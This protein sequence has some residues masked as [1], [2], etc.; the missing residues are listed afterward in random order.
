MLMAARLA[1]VSS[2]IAAVAAIAIL[3]I[4]VWIGVETRRMAAAATADAKAARDAVGSAAEQ[5][6]IARESLWAQQKPVLIEAVRLVSINQHD[7]EMVKFQDGTWT[8]P[9]L[10]EAHVLC[11]SGKAAYVSLPERNVGRGVA[12]V[13]SATLLVEGTGSEPLRVGGAYLRR[14]HVPPRETVRM[15]FVIAPGTTS[16]EAV[17]DAINEAGSLSVSIGYSDLA[18]N[19]QESRYD[20]RRELGWDVAF[21]RVSPSSRV[22]T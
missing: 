22:A 15:D 3:I 9:M 16:Y 6:A 14:R 10:G 19:A 7:R 2:T 17:E 12:V 5:A 8:K 4:Y 20:L 18:G 11:A 1:D 13:D 21:L